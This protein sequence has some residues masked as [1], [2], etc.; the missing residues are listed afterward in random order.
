MTMADEEKTTLNPLKQL[1]FVA[2]DELFFPK[3]LAGTIKAL[4]ALLED[5]GKDMGEEMRI[6]WT[7]NISEALS[8]YADIKYGIPVEKQ[9]VLTAAL[10]TLEGRFYE[11]VEQDYVV[12]NS[13]YEQAAITIESMPIG[14]LRDIIKDFIKRDDFSNQ[15]LGCLDY[16]S[17]LL[18]WHYGYTAAGLWDLA[19]D[20]YCHMDGKIGEARRCYER[21]VEIIE[22]TKLKE[23]DYHKMYLCHLYLSLANILLSHFDAWEEVDGLYRNAADAIFFDVQEKSNQEYN[24]ICYIIELC[25][26][27]ETRLQEPDWRPHVN[28]KVPDKYK[29]KLYRLLA[30]LGQ[31]ALD[32]LRGDFEKTEE[33]P[34]PETYYLIAALSELYMKLNEYEKC[35]DIIRIGRKIN[36]DNSFFEWTWD[37]LDENIDG[38]GYF[39]WSMNN[40]SR[41]EGL[42]QRPDYKEVRGQ[43]EK[44]QES[45]ERQEDSHRRQEWRQMRQEKQIENA[46]EMLSNEF[47]NID[48]AL[49]KLKEEQKDISSIESTQIKLHKAYPWLQQAS[50]IGSV[51]NA[52]FLYDSLKIRNW[53]EVV[54]GLCN[55][56]EEELKQFLYKEYP[57]LIA[58]T[59]KQKETKS[60]LYFIA[61][62]KKGDNYQSWIN[63]VNIKMP[64]YKDFLL[65]ELPDKLAELKEL[66]NPSSHGKMNKTKNAERAREIVLGKPDN[67]GLLQCLVELH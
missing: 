52:E 39:I 32:T 61:N 10:K 11:V 50:N 29:E 27:I 57:D 44:M 40:I 16:L 31:K 48:V 4:N 33:F 59:Q 14:L 2:T 38:V 20:A 60:L 15:S 25:G 3:E 7:I 17:A 22:N 53:G 66:R 49:G 62:I 23:N 13:L 21:G 47:A 43:M 42:L 12:A 5:H 51:V 55:A 34:V 30:E 67:P 28:I 45:H 36:F 58:Q 41:A 24:D 65:Y 46:K 8:K 19:G 35:A 6:Q 56:V 9:N 26:V 1:L 54:G 63:F 64:K 37:G 18:Y